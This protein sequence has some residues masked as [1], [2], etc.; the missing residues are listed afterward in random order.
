MTNHNPQNERH[1]LKRDAA[2]FTEC[3]GVANFFAGI[4]DNDDVAK[5]QAEA[6]AE[7]MTRWAAFLLSVA[8]S[9]PQS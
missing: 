7:V 2:A 1:D 5:A 9:A 8:P 4:I 3:A 6:D